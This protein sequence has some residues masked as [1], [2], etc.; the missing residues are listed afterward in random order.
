MV[1]SV[2]GLDNQSSALELS[3]LVNHSSHHS[4]LLLSFLFLFLAPD[5]EYQK[6]N[7]TNDKQQA[8]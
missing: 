6:N 1:V 7:E 3:I 4:V 8:E 5:A 2:R